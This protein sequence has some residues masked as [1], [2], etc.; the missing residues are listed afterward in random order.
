[1]R[2]RDQER[3]GSLSRLVGVLRLS[4]PDRPEWNNKPRGNALGSPKEEHLTMH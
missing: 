1:L 2:D 3:A 4:K